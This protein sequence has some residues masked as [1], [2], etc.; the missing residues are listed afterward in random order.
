MTTEVIDMSQTRP[1]VLVVACGALL[2]AGLLVR[3]VVGARQPVDVD[4]R[5]PR[6]RRIRP[7]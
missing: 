4:S 1:R 3:T 6:P 5:S 2:A 7:R